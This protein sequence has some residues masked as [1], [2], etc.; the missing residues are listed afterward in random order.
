VGEVPAAAVVTDGDLEPSALR[1]FVAARLA[2]YKVPQLIRRFP[3]LPRNA[4]GKLDK[5]EIRRL[6]ERTPGFVHVPPRGPVERRL[7]A[8]WS[9]VLG[10][11]GI[12]AHDNFF[13]LGGHSL[14][15]ARVLSRVRS[16]WG[17]ELPMRVVFERP[18]VA[19][20]AVVLED[21]PSRAPEPPIVPVPR[22]AAMPVSFAQ[23]RLWFVNELEPSG[24]Y[25]RPS[26]F[27]LRGLLRAD[28]LEAAL[29]EIVRRH[30]VLRTSF[31]SA[32]GIPVQVI[33]PHGAWT[34]PV[35]D[36]SG[37]GS[38]AER[39]ARAGELAHEEVHASFDMERG[40]L[41][42]ARLVRLAEEDHMLLLN[43]HHVV[44]DAWSTSVLLRELNALYPVLAAG[45]P[46]PLPELALQYAD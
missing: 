20:L 5:A 42:R 22:T 9:D 18:T 13:E 32:D 4:A 16:E 27:R 36:L 11:S 43:L 21:G 19:E 45:E 38:V 3:R 26:G 15:L 35:D 37:M 2:D 7:A 33:A 30:E 29:S 39:E 14:L 8:V 10:R 31:Q 17:I 46:S 40:P 41:F 6:M 25:N 34:L 1:E 44:S 23:Q 24:T 28:I 12:G